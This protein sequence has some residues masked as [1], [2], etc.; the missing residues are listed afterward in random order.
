M[1]CEC[2]LCVCVF[3][4]VCVCLSVCMLKCVHMCVWACVPHLPGDEVLETQQLV[5]VLRVLLGELLSEEG[6]TTGHTHTHTN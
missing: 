2:V 4:C 3:V 5:A 1:T 6:L